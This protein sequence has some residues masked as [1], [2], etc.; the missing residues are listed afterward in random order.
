MPSGEF[1]YPS[2][3]TERPDSDFTVRT[4]ILPVQIR[5]S[6]R[7]AWLDTGANVSI[8]PREIA[9]DLIRL[10]SSS[11]SEGEYSL[12]GLVKIPYQSY[13]MDVN[14]L[15]YIPDT[16]PQMD[17]DPYQTSSSPAVTL[18]NVDFQVPTM[19]WPEIA[20]RIE[21]SSPISLEDTEMGW[22][23][24]GLYGVLE[25]LSLSFVGNNAVTLSTYP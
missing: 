6:V 11:H 23:I 19:T 7:W 5:N 24:L 1:T 17:L 20:D 8:L 21:A 10:R 14:I 16:I 9:R 13:S 12:A 18:N 4:F 22:V 15:E 3:R 2:K 25:Q